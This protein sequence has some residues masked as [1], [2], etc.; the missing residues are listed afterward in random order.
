MILGRKIGQSQLLNQ[1]N[2][3]AM[4]QKSKSAIPGFRTLDLVQKCG[5]QSLLKMR[6]FQTTN[7][8]CITS[9]YAHRGVVCP[10]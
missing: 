3:T 1:L 4:P 5:P 9:N 8:H 7:L 2:S 10:N 6:N